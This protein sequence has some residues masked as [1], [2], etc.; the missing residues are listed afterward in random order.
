MTWA[1]QRRWAWLRVVSLAILLCP[2]KAATAEADPWLDFVLAVREAD[3]ASFGT[4]ALLIGVNARDPRELR[5]QTPLHWVARFD[6]LQM[7]EWLLEAG[8]RL[9]AVDATGKTPLAV[10]IEHGASDTAALLIL[11]GAPVNPP[12][13]SG[14]S[15]LFLAV[16]HRNVS[17]AALLLDH[18][19]SADNVVELLSGPATVADIVRQGDDLAMQRLFK[20][21]GKLK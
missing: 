18:G 11:R 9:D 17:I 16:V 5:E 21:K 20:A 7:A 6:R 19:A 15:P 8:A 12:H 4:A 13:P 10:A 1:D 14:R 3:H 2:V